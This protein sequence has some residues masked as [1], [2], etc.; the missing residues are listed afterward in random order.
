MI[1]E[2]EDMAKKTQKVSKTSFWVCLSI[3]IFLMVGSALFPWPPNFIIEHSI[4]QA[5]GWLFGF[6]ALGQLPDIIN[7]GRTAKIQRGNTVFTIGKDENND[8][9]DDDWQRQQEMNNTDSLD[10]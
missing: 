8:G 7:L 1:K 2:I 6:A 3:S 4:F 9:M 5:V 10:D